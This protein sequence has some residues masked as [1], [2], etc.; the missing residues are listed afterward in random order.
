VLQVDEP[1]P[2]REH[3]HRPERDQ[4]HADTRESEEK[5]DLVGTAAMTS[6]LEGH[7]GHERSADGEEGSRRWKKSA[8]SAACRSLGR[9]EYRRPVLRGKDRGSCNVLWA[10]EQVTE[11]R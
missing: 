7:A 2:E 4:Q 10:H 1:E 5:R 8:Q 9:P 6:G 11:E 3:E